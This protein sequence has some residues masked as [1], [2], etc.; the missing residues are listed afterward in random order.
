M[1]ILDNI[2]KPED[3]DKL[4]TA[5]L[6]LLCTELRK[7]LIENI[8]N[9]GGHLASN[10][11]AVELNVALNRVYNSERDRLMFDVGHQCYVHKILTGRRDEF[12]TLRQNGGIS[13]FPKPAE[14]EADCFVSGHASTSVSVA[15]GMARART[16]MDE[17]YDVVAIIGDGALTGGLAYE[18]L[19]NIGQSDEPIVVVLNDNAMSINGNVGGVE[20][21][22][23]S[24]RVRAG[25]LGFKRWYR[26]SLG[27]IKPIHVIVHSVKEMIKS[28]FLSKNIFDDMGFYY[29]GPVDGNDIGSLEVALAWAKDMKR[30]VLLHV[31][32]KKGKGYEFAENEPNKYHGVGKFDVLTGKLGISTRDFSEVFGEKMLAL[33]EKDKS[34]VGISA[35]MTDG[36]GFTAFSEKY[37]NRYFDVGIAEGHA[38]SSAAGMAKQGLLPVIS[39]YSSFLQRAYDMLIHDISLLNLH[40][41]ICVDRAGLVGNDGETHQG[42][43]DVA[44]LSTVPNMQIL[45]PASFNELRLMMDKAIYKMSGPVAIRYPRGG[46]LEYMAENAE[47]TVLKEGDKLTLVTY[48]IM[49]NSA[50]SACRILDEE[51]ISVELIKLAQ[52]AP[53]DID[54]VKKSVEKT[55]KL[56]VL[57]DVCETGSVGERICANLAGDLC[58]TKRLLNLGEG[59]V[60]H[61]TVSELQKI[62]GIDGES[63]AKVVKEMVKNG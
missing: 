45:C 28:V 62:C 36:T 59:I 51:G 21:F 14:S 33:A 48:G 40:V 3:L 42:A 31:L 27:K 58:F 52:V 37:P 30:P 5:D 10:L 22:L 15:A 25:Y 1:S 47:N 16:L 34:L 35:A 43:F 56:L 19:C 18:G 46:E 32:T 60:E 49:I 11:G 55:G 24:M 38:V 39:V 17:D 44:Y 50:I 6:E 26:N 23:S 41:V 57:E 54:L 61:G 4:S 12:S 53:L 8:A 20:S 63:V 13:G 29:L 2:N 9:T 7:F